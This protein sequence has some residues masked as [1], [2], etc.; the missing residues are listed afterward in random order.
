VTAVTAVTARNR[1]LAPMKRLKRQRRSVLAQRERRA[2]RRL[3]GLCINSDNHGN[4]THG[5]LCARCRLKHTESRRRV[6]GR[7]KL[8]ELLAAFASQI[9]ICTRRAA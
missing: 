8:R 9:Q 4:A 2:H 6:S 3:M 5:V 7:P 1:D